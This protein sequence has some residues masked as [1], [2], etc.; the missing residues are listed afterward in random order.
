MIELSN[1]RPNCKALQNAIVEHLF[2][3]KMKYDYRKKMRIHFIY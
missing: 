1:K 3:Y 2:H